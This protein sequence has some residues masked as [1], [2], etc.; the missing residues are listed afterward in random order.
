MAVETE[1]E[2]GLMEDPNSGS[3]KL[4]FFYIQF[5]DSRINDCARLLLENLAFVCIDVWLFAM[6]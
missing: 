6:C 4:S 1:N 5:M 3:A 2:M